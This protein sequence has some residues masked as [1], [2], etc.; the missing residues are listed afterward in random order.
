MFE[1]FVTTYGNKLLGLIIISICGCLGYAAKQICKA[2]LDD[3]TK[4]SIAMTAVRFVEQV[5]KDI[6]GADKLKKALETAKYA[7]KKYKEMKEGN[8][9]D[10]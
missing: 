5:W 10:N 2:Y 1:F 3:D 6:H 9:D 4:R 8:E 7:V